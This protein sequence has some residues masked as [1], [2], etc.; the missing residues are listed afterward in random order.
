M[1]RRTFM[2]GVAAAGPAAAGLA[3]TAESRVE[4]IVGALSDRTGTVRSAGSGWIAR[5]GSTT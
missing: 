2:A 1:D 4:I 5:R 3:R